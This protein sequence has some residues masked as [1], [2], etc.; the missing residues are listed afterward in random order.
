MFL[1]SLIILL[2]VLMLIS[3]GSGLYFLMVDQ[4]KAHQKRLLTSLTL[5]VTLAALLLLLIF[6]GFYTG[7][8]HSQA[9][10]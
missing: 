4:G 6:Y 10:W 2:V 5:R 1:K 9:P 8:L 3:L 7:Q